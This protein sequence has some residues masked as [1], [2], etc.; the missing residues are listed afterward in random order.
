MTR[1]LG[2]A[3]LAIAA[4]SV[5]LIAQAPA[6]GGAMNPDIRSRVEVLAYDLYIRQGSNHGDDVSDWLEAERLTLGATK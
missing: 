6:G 2:I 5:A 3:L 1:R 4:L